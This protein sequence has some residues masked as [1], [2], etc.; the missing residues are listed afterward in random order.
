MWCGWPVHTL[1]T[2]L[3]IRSIAISGLLVMLKIT[4]AWLWRGCGDGLGGSGGRVV[5]VVVVHATWWWWWW[6]YMQRGGGGGVIEQFL[7]VTNDAQI[8]NPATRQSS[9]S[10]SIPGTWK[11]A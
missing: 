4:A 11:L 9:T 7:G 6:L 2:L 8:L 10:T 1:R 3:L 5:V